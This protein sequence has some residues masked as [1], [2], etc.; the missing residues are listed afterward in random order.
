MKDLVRKIF[1]SLGYDVCHWDRI[2]AHPFRDIQRIFGSRDV[3]VIFDVGANEGQSSAEFAAFFPSAAIH[4]FEPFDSS[5][6]CLS[7]IS[8]RFKNIKTVKAAVGEVSG[9]RTMFV[10]N[11]S[12]TNSLL[13]KSAE[14]LRYVSDEVM[15]NTGTI[16][17]QVTTLD[18]YCMLEG[19][20]FIDVLK[21]GR[22]RV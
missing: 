10:N 22:P 12:P 15:A 8:K 18:E 21:N 6:E 14:S 11:F 4:S 16:T 1:R 20:E 17:V 9:L 13:R 3:K 7:S 2:G 19:I 5:F